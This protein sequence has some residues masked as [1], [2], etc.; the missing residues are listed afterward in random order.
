VIELLDMATPGN[1]QP[2]ACSDKNPIDLDTII[3]SDDD[4]ESN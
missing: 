2:A 3:S 4:D 1:D